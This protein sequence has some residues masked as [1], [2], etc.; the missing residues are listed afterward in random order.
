MSDYSEYLN[1]EAS[2]LKWIDALMYTD[3]IPDEAVNAAE[4]SLVSLQNSLAFL[5]DFRTC[6]E[7]GASIRS[8]YVVDDCY[9]VCDE[10]FKPYMIREFSGSWTSSTEQNR[11]GG[12][13][14]YTTDDGSEVPLNIYWTEWE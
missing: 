2:I 8:G 10:C 14:S 13:Y 4:H 5:G 9:Y 12:Y 6:D 11:L 7:C 1:A 3:G